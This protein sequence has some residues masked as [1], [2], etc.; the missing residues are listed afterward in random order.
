MEEA[1]DS[2][3]GFSNLQIVKACFLYRFS[4]S[5]LSLH[6]IWNIWNLEYVEYKLP[7]KKC[8][9]EDFSPLFDGSLVW[10]ENDR[11]IQTPMEIPSFY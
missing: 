9:R 5:P 8:D 1:L 4:L 10:F 11:T 6:C 2:H 7:C 3:P